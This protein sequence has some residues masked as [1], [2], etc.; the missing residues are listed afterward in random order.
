MILAHA[1][2]FIAA[3]QIQCIDRQS[4]RIHF[5]FIAFNIPGQGILPPAE[6]R[7]HPHP[8]PSTSILPST[9]HSQT[10]LTP[11]SRKQHHAGSSGGLGSRLLG[12]EEEDRAVAQVE[13][14]EVFSLVRDEGAEV[15]SHDAMPGGT[16]SLIELCT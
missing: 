16:F 8:I 15:S 14:D 1:L 10:S 6:P 13:V 9:A 12:L 5:I 2:S 11:P 3:V 4:S 7:F